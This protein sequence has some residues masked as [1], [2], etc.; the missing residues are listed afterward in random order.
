MYSVTFLGRYGFLPLQWSV[1]YPSTTEQVQMST[2]Y[3]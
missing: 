3:R 2:V 1:A